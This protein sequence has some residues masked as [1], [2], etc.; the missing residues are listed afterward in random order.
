MNLLF[1]G[2]GT[3]T[4]V[5]QIGCS[6]S[7]CR[8]ADS[9]D[10]RLRASVF[11]TEGDTKILIDCGPDLRQ[12][13]LLNDINSVSAILLT[14]D[15]Y[16][17]VGGLDDVRP[18]GDTQLYAEKR[19]LS[20][21]Q[22]NMPYCFA[23]IKYPGVPI[24]HLHEINE[25]IF[26]INNLKIVPVRIM[27]AKLPILGFR[28]GKVAYLTDIK[29]IDDRSIEKLQNLDILVM[30]AL[31]IK[32]HIAHL[33]LSEAIEIATKIGARKTYFTHMSHD[34]GL[35]E[36]INKSLPENIE[37]AYDGLQLSI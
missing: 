1:L 31:R 22:R 6:C 37:L 33:S 3:S 19:V 12:Q 8:S 14:H 2:T 35:H 9:K 18:L 32:N 28:I 20:V 34:I 23:D 15:H 36:E 10:K 29:T 5:P 13:L 26:Y 17:H 24:I 11:I 16:D 21:I 4:G 25:N 7:T 30:N 27:H